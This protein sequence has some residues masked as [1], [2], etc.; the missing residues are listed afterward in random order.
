MVVLMLW[1]C[2]FGVDI[3]DVRWTEG[4]DADM[5]AGKEA[6]E[7]APVAGANSAYAGLL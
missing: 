3:I 5:A 4:D 7:E 2:A 6:L 1:R